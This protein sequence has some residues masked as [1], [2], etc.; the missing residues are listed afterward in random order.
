MAGAL[1]AVPSERHPV[2][3]RAMAAMVLRACTGRVY[4][5]VL[6]LAR[7]HHASTTANLRM[8]TSLR[9]AKT[10]S[11]TTGRSC[12]EPR[13]EKARFR[14]VDWCST[15][16]RSQSPHSCGAGVVGCASK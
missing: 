13:K 6:A 16:E 9:R 14:A 4:R 11:L 2:S 1:V 12:P 15:C 10:L 3:N 7:V 5:C 8:A